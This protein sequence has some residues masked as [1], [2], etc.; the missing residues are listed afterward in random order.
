MRFEV[1]IFDN[2][3]NFVDKVDR[4]G[5]KSRADLDRYLRMTGLLDDKTI[6]LVIKKLGRGE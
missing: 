6:K 4:K 3:G 5:F 1:K 2:Q